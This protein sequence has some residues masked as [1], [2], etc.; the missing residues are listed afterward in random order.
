MRNLIDLSF[1]ADKHV[2]FRATWIFEKIFLKY[3]DFYVQNIEF[4][5][6]RFPDVKYVS[7]Q[8]YYAK[9]LML[10]TH[11]DASAVIKSKINLTDLHNVVKKCFDW[12]IDPKVK[13]AVKVFAC[14]ALFNLRN[15]YPVV[16][17]ELENQITFLMTQNASPGII[18][19]GRKLLI[20]LKQR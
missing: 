17:D 18:S 16:K 1:D 13:T 7:C 12:L 9:I 5:L 19:K 2:A 8:R 20:K 10:I 15:Y 14:D 6:G 4:P 11:P 3:P